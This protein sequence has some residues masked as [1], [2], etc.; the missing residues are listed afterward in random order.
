MPPRR[1]WLWVCWTGWPDEVTVPVIVADAGYGRS[2]SFRLALEERGWSYIM[3]VD[4]KE[5]P[6]PGN[7]T[8]TGPHRGRGNDQGCALRSQVT[9]A[10][11]R[12]TTW[13]SCG[14]DG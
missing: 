1:V 4:P 13:P 14:A 8:D 5:I 12:L 3:A 9:A 7:G 2:V 6:Q 11:A 10:D